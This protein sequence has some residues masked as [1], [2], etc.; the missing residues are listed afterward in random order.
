MMPQ[1]TNA[2][3]WQRMRTLCEEI[4]AVQSQLAANEARLYA[5]LKARYTQSVSKSD[6]PS[7]S[8][9]EDETCLRVILRNVRVR[10]NLRK[11]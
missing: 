3:F 11:N 5:E 6:L 7:Q 1:E 4:D 8:G 9:F 10:E 2:P